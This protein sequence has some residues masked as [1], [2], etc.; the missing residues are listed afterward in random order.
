MKLPGDREVKPDSSKADIKKLQIELRKAGYDLG[1]SGPKGDGVD[2]DYGPKTRM[3]VEDIQQRN[4]LPVNPLKVDKATADAINKEVESRPVEGGEIT[5]EAEVNIGGLAGVKITVK[6]KTVADV[7]RQLKQA[8]DE[9]KKL[10][11]DDGFI[12]QISPPSGVVKNADPKA[13][14]QRQWPG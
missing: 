7:I 1:N 8:I 14:L 10:F 12:V 9:L 3:A 13:N 6:G 11:K 2:G 5:I 4:D